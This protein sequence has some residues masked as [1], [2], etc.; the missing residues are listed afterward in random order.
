VFLGDCSFINMFKKILFVL[1]FL[2]VVFVSTAPVLAKYGL[3]ETAH[4]AQYS[5]T[6]IYS[7]ISKIVSIILS[8]IGIVFLTIM[9]YAGLRWMTAR[10]N[11]EFTT[12]AKDAMFAAIIGLILVVASYGIATFI[13]SKLTQ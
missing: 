2:S 5:E 9:F 1:V 6:D 11:E 10:G 12:K 7:Y 4:Q 13:F 8:L 3:E